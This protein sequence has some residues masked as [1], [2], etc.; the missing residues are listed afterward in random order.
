M[1]PPWTTYEEAPKIVYQQCNIYV[2]ANAFMQRAAYYTFQKGCHSLSLIL[3]IQKVIQRPLNEGVP[4]HAQFSISVVVVTT[5]TLLS[6]YFE[7]KIFLKQAP[8]ENA[9]FTNPT[10]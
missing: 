5:G 4:L 8:L 7:Q 10:L 2:R 3:Y 1:H 6:E 9:L